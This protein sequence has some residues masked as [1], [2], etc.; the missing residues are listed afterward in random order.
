[1]LQYVVEG[2]SISAAIKTTQ[3][4]NN[5]KKKKQ[6]RFPGALGLKPFLIGTIQIEICVHLIP[7]YQQMVKYFLS[8]NI[9]FLLH[10]NPI[11]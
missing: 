3:F 11:C 10:F 2:H 4:S 7:N 1:M 8:S 5:N 6:D 9:Y